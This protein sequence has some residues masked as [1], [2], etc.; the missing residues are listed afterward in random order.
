LERHLQLLQLPSD[1]LYLAKLYNVPEGRLREVLA[2]PSSRRRE[3]LLLALEEDM[4][5]RELRETVKSLPVKKPRKGV[6]IPTHKKAA[7]RLRSFLKLARR[8]DFS[9][10][11]EEVAVEFSVTTEDANELLE[12]AEYLEN[13]ASWLREMYE[14]RK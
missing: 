7:S 4:T 14:R 13:Q 9:Q 1:L 11:F 2:A 12:T 10:N 5:A 6:A 8:Q 3:L